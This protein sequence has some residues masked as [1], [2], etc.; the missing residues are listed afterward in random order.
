MPPDQQDINEHH[1]HHDHDNDFISDIQDINSDDPDLAISPFLDA[2]PPPPS[3]PPPPQQQQQDVSS[4]IPSQPSHPIA[5]T[6]NATTTPRSKEAR[7]PKEPE[8]PFS[9][10]AR[11]PPGVLDFRERVFSL[12]QPMTFDA[13]TW[14]RYWP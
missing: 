9:V 14:E 8:R 7:E 1:Q 12:E 6:S 2:P 4:H 10:L 3:P 11:I 5:I 13:Q